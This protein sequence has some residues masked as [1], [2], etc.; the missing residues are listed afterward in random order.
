MKVSLWSKA[1][2]VFL[3]IET[4]TR[5]QILTTTS[6]SLLFILTTAS[7]LSLTASSSACVDFAPMTMTSWLNLGT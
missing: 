7:V 1:A 6:I 4:D 2:E 5:K 3:T